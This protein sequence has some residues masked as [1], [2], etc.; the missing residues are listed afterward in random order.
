VNVAGISPPTPI[1]E[2]GSRGIQKAGESDGQDIP[3]RLTKWNYQVNPGFD[4]RRQ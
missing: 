1:A 4:R 2:G 3:E